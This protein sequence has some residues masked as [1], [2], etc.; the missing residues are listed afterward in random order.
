MR[1][2]SNATHWFATALPWNA[3]RIVAI[4]AIRVRGRFRGHFVPYVELAGSDGRQ[5]VAQMRYAEMR[6]Y[7]GFCTQ[8]FRKHG[9]IFTDER[10]EGP[11]CRARWND[12]THQHFAAGLRITLRSHQ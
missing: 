9:I 8:L 5:R 10:F 1:M 7:R 11:G 12:F 6:G 2:I 4:T 3:N